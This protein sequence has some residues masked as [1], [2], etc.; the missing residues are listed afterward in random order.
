M[1]M[2]FLATDPLIDAP[3][4]LGRDW[5]PARKRD[6]RLVGQTEGIFANYLKK[7]VWEEN[8]PSIRVR[9][10]LSPAKVTSIDQQRKLE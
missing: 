4:P 2:V 8:D 9:D 3:V 10:R 6:W 1:V 7:K 5:R